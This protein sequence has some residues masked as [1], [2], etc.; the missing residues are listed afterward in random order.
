[1]LNWVK[2]S[3]DYNGVITIYPQQPREYADIPKC[4]QCGGLT[5]FLHFYSRV[6]RYLQSNEEV[7]SFCGGV[8]A[9]EFIRLKQELEKDK[10]GFS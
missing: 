7:P 3:R 5:Q 8:C 6:L 2:S 1:M 10:N 4:S 9:T